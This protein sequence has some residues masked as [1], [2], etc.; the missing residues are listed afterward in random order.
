MHYYH[1]RRSHIDPFCEPTPDR[2]TGKGFSPMKAA[3]SSAN[4]LL[5]MAKPPTFLAFRVTREKTDTAFNCLLKFVHEIHLDTILRQEEGFFREQSW[6]ATR[7]LLAKSPY[8]SAM[9]PD[10]LLSSRS[11]GVA[12][13][14]IGTNLHV[15]SFSEC[16]PHHGHRNREDK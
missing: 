1:R 6:G 12:T 7:A 11:H 4:S 5:H 9:S 13:V 15:T 14:W 16:Q 8:S 10:D 2:T 3:T